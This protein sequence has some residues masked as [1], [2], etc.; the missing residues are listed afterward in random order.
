MHDV[1]MVTDDIGPSLDIITKLMHNQ[2][3]TL[4]YL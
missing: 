4:A 2:R 1:I 3:Y